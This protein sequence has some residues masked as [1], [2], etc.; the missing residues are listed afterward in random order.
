MQWSARVQHDTPCL[1]FLMNYK[2]L[3]SS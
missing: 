3:R 2:K 1:L